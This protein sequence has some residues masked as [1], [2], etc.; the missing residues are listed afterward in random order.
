MTTFLAVLVTRLKRTSRSGN[1]T[2]DNSYKN[3]SLPQHA[4]VQITTDVYEEVSCTTAAPPSSQSPSLCLNVW[5][6]VPS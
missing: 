2:T 5:L 3:A 1:S 6:H 4:T